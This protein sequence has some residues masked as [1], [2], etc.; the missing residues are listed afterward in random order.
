MLPYI[1]EISQNTSLLEK[2]TRML[3][4]GIS[5]KK[6][7]NLTWLVRIMNSSVAMLALMVASSGVNATCSWLGHQPEIPAKLARLKKVK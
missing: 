6:R 1:Q 5:M 3:R 7:F 4:R 2:I